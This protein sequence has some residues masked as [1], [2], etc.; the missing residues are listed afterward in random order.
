MMKIFPVNPSPLL[1]R[2]ISRICNGYI[3]GSLYTVLRVPSW[4]RWLRLRP[5]VGSCSPLCKFV[6]R[7]DFVGNLGRERDAEQPS[8]DVDICRCLLKSFSTFLRSVRHRFSDRNLRLL[9]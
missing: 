3:R 7:P 9:P 4:L 5:P 1:S 2:L 8:N 6:R